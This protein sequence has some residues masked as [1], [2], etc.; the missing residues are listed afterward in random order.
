MPDMRLSPLPTSVAVVGSGQRFSNLELLRTLLRDGRGASL[1]WACTFVRES[2]TRFCPTIPQKLHGSADCLPFNDALGFVEWAGILSASNPAPNAATALPARLVA[3]GN[4][5]RL[6]AELRKRSASPFP[7]IQI[8][9]EGVFFVTWRK[10]ALLMVVGA[11]S[12]FL[13]GCSGLTQTATPGSPAKAI[14]IGVSPS[15][16]SFG[17]LTVGTSSTSQS[18]I[19]SNQGASPLTLTGLTAGTAFVI[20]SKPSLPL[21]LSPTQTASIGVTFRPTASGNFTGT[22]SITSDATTGTS[23]VSLSGTGTGTSA[24]ASLSPSTLNFPS[25]T[26]NSTSAPMSVTLSNSGSAALSISGVSTTGNFQQTNNCGTQL[27][28]GATC[29]LSVTFTPAASGAQTGTLSV[30]DSAPGSPQSISLSGT[31]LTVVQQLSATPSSVSFG[32]VNVGASTTQGVTLANT[33]NSNVNISQVSA[34]DSGFS[35]AGLT[36]PLTLTAGQSTT[37]TV[38]FAPATSGTLTGI[39][40]V[41]SNATNSPVTVGLSGTGVQPVSHSVALTWNASTSPVGGYYVYRG[42]H[43]GGPYTKL[44]LSSLIALTFTDGAVQ[45]GQ[46]YFYV[47]SAVDSNTVESGYSNEV[48]AAIPTP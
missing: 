34:S 2:P 29:A 14:S 46:T 40:N 37:F 5:S 25:Q 41:V 22:L 4:Y 31:G 26:V 43:S 32:S 1:G 6:F 33:G 8:L 39:I 10:L 30:A 23:S 21:T 7:S 19:I 13:F 3:V 16:L 36:T 28:S 35:I 44:N 27:A 38:T 20:T 12:G 24:T 45:A 17:S 18:V 11:G 47:I 48:S 9:H 42:S 15:T